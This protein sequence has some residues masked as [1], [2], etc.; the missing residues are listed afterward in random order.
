MAVPNEEQESQEEPVDDDDHDSSN[1]KESNSSSSL[2]S[3]LYRNLRNMGLAVTCTVNTPMYA[4]L[5]A[6]TIFGVALYKAHT[7]PSSSLSSLSSSSSLS[8]LSQLPWFRWSM[9]LYLVYCVTDRS[10]LTGW[11][12]S[13]ATREWL[14]SWRN[15]R[16][17]A[18]YFPVT[19][20]KTCK[21][22]DD[23][24][25]T[26]TD[27][28]DNGNSKKKRNFIFLYH[29]HGV[30][31]MGV[32]TALNTNACDFDKIFPGISN[33]WGV[34]LNVA[35]YVPL[36][37]EWML[38]LGFVSANKATL[39]Q[40]LLQGDSIVLVP[41]GAVEALHAHEE[42]TSN[43]CVLCLARRRGFI[44]LAQETGAALVP[45]FA[46]GENRVF[47]TLATSSTATTNG[48]TTGTVVEKNSLGAIVKSWLF[49]GQQALY[50]TCSFSTP[51]LTWPFPRK[52]PIDVVVG[53]PVVLSP[54]D[55]VET[56]FQQYTVALCE[57]YEA[58]KDQ[59]GYGHVTL[60]I[61]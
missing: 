35:F 45:C 46:F 34:T 5:I 22:L 9:W 1:P 38:A 18:E 6:Q 43:A 42:S 28:D 8:S 48:A 2:A 44:R 4:M 55:D 24:S 3:I 41:G 21:L 58:H 51:I 26:D 49:A 50:K 47:D 19:L 14:R 29:P 31:A 57:L 10:P 15:A 11:N 60:E 7:L 20:H 36:Y 23:N 25:N 54:S 33:R 32:N 59:Y 40:K 61:V 37:R 30:I 17:T 52:R 13:R 12:L 27:D 16:W 53:A 39:R 56:C